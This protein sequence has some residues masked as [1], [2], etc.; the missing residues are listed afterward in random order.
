MDQSRTLRFSP[1]ELAKPKAFIMVFCCALSSVAAKSLMRASNSSS[2]PPC[3]TK[4]ISGNLSS[5]GT[6]AVFSAS[7]ASDVNTYDTEKRKSKEKV[8]NR[9]NRDETLSSS[10]SLFTWIWLLSP[11]PIPLNFGFLHLNSSCPPKQSPKRQKLPFSPSLS[12]NRSTQHF[13]SLFSSSF[14]SFSLFQ[15]SPGICASP[16]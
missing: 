16:R 14:S 13:S 2:P 5:G 11:S 4:R 3:K 15:S 10:N 9:G 7:E 12:L 6:A 8:S 1:M